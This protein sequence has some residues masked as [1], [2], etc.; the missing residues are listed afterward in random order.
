M[1]QATTIRLLRLLDLGLDDIAD[2][3]TTD[4]NQT[5]Q[6]LRDHLA[7]LERRGRDQRRITAFLIDR[8]T[9]KEP[10]M[11]VGIITRFEPALTL[12]IRS[13]TVGIPDLSQCTA[14][15]PATPPFG[16]RRHSTNQSRVRLPGDA[17]QQGTVSSGFG[18][19]PVADR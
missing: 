4:R 2:L 16:L 14:R 6:W 5:A 12:L 18:G 19:M 1:Q 3:L 7:V 13:R 8:P 11:T 10:A 9:T 15:T 17:E